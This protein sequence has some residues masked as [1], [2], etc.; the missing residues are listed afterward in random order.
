M[1]DCTVTTIYFNG[2]FWTALIEQTIDGVLYI[3]RHV[4]GA[5]PSNAELLQWMLYEWSL[6]PRFKAVST[7]RMKPEKQE[8]RTKESV[9]RSLQRYKEAQEVFAEQKKA[10]AKKQRHLS[11]KE[12]Y[13]QDKIKR[14]EKKHH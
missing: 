9:S 6:V 10:S 12:Q 4:F 5:E 11:K 2:Q 14:K 13:E 3:G 1:S 8:R 7:V